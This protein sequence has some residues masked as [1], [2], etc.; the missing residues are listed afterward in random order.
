MGTGGIVKWATVILIV[1]G[2]LNWGLVG[3]FNFNVVTTLFGDTSM[4][5]RVVY[6]LI[7]LAGLY[8]IFMIMTKK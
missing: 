6:M 1:V 7:G 5:T 2:A 8:K 4:I 3:A